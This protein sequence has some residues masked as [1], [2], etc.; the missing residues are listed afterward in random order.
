MRSGSFNVTYITLGNFTR[1]RH[2]C[3]YF[4]ML[5]ATPKLRQAAF[6]SPYPLKLYTK[7]A[8]KANPLGVA[9]AVAKAGPVNRNGAPRFH[10]A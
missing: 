3:E 7:A 8:A 5:T 10:R 1:L 2:F 4:E 6:N 9:G